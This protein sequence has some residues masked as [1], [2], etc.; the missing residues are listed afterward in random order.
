MV[1]F[2]A[3]SFISTAVFG[4]FV[5]GAID[6]VGPFDQLR[7]RRW[8]KSETVLR[9]GS[10]ELGTRLEVG[11]VELLAALAVQE[12]FVIFRGEKCALMMIE[13]P[14]NFRRWRILEVHD[15]VLVA[16]EFGFVK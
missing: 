16:G 1:S 3:G 8:M 2:I 5:L 4:V 12:M 10:Q 15:G 14:G 13:P 6:N 9:D 11:I 7:D